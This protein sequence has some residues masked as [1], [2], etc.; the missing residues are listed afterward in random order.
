MLP[1]CVAVLPVVRKSVAEHLATCGTWRLPV[2]EELAR[3]L[4]GDVEILR[5]ARWCHET[6]IGL[7]RGDSTTD[8]FDTWSR[9][10][11]FLESRGVYSGEG[12]VIGVAAAHAGMNVDFDSLN[13]LAS[14]IQHEGGGPKN[15]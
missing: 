4:A 5:R 3:Q 9:G 11:D 7:T 15:E 12:G 13:S 10:A 2:F 14:S 6:L 8:F 1:T